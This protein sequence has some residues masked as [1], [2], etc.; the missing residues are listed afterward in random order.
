MQLWI[1]TIHR[2]LMIASAP[3]PWLTR[4]S[5]EC[6]F[7]VDGDGRDIRSCCN[8]CGAETYCPAHRRVASLGQPTPVAKLLEE[9]ASLGV[10]D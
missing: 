10:F 1:M 5:G 2:S 8:P 9:L 4:L 7:P 6:A 3:R